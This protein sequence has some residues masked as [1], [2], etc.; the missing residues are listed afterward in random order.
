MGKAGKAIVI[1]DWERS[2]LLEKVSSRQKL[3]VL[4]LREGDK[5]TKFFY[6]EIKGSSESSVFCMDGRSG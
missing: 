4:W 5:C 3:K 2:S 1:N 6:L